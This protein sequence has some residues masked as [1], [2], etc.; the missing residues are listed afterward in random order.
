[1]LVA[2]QLSDAEGNTAVER[3][4]L[5]LNL[6][7]RSSMGEISGEA[8]PPVGEGSGLTT[9]SCTVPAGWFSSFETR[10]A[11]AAVELRY[12]PTLR[13]K[14]V[15]GDV[16]LQRSPTQGAPPPLP[17]LLQPYA[18]KLLQPRAPGMLRLQ[19]VCTQARLPRAA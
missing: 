7:L 4:G 9:C 17:P 5:S 14:E 16:R 18:S 11:S 2:V 19:H 10:G 12:G 13:L 1:M 15:V 6:V 8:C 3:S